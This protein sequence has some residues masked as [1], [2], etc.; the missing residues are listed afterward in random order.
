M[1]VYMLLLDAKVVWYHNLTVYGFF[2]LKYIYDCSLYYLVID[3]RRNVCRKNYIRPKSYC[4][5]QRRS[6]FPVF[7][8]L[9]LY[10][11]GYWNPS[12]FIQNLVVC[13]KILQ[14]L[15]GCWYLIYFLSGSGVHK[16]PSTQQSTPSNMY[17]A[18]VH[19][20]S[21]LFS[22]SHEA[23]PTSATVRAP[24]LFFHRQ[25]CFRWPDWTVWTDSKGVLNYQ[26]LMELANTSIGL[27]GGSVYVSFN[28]L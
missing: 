7:V 26:K 24:M 23:T 11:T 16:C 25:N 12:R 5:L 19:C 28:F 1:G 15:K 2:S 21:L 27:P 14:K 20:M 17:W 10:Y 6:C 4:K 22:M 3:H 18:K 13:Y 8:L 9:T